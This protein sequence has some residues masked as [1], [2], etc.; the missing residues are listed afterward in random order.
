M[1]NDVYTAS[2]SLPRRQTDPAWLQDYFLGTGHDE[3]TNSATFTF[4]KRS[5]R[6]YAVTC[7]HVL[8][9]LADEKVVPGAR[10]PTLALHLDHAALNLSYFVAVGKIEHTVKAPEAEGTHRDVDIAIARLSDNYWALLQEKKDKV[11]IDLDTWKEPAWDKVSYCLAAGYPDEHKSRVEDD[12]LGKVSA[13]FACVC[14]EVASPLAR[15][16][17]MITLS[18]QLEEHHGYF[19]SGMSGGPVYAIE[20]DLNEAEDRDFF[21]VGIIFEGFPS[22]GRREVTDTDASAAFLTDSDLFFRALTLT[23]E[24]FDDW[25][26]QVDLGR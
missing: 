6:I 17:P 23:P 15:S 1:E 10:N 22:S 19:F 5:G 14:V 25:L 4:I 7:G 24:I 2:Q 13:P 12:R 11:P 16:R 8:D 20:G 26:R 3:S 9:G 18:S 21:H